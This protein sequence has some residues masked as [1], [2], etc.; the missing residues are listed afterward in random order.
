MWCT[1]V[2]SAQNS[3]HTKLQNS[4]SPSL[5][6]QPLSTLGFITHAVMNYKLY[7][8]HGYVVRK[9]FLG[10]SSQQNSSHLH[11]ALHGTELFGDIG[12][13]HMFLTDFELAAINAV[14]EVFPEPADA[15]AKGCFLHF[16]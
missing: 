6:A 10:H 14:R 15:V 4:R 11:R 12:E 16:R 1:N 8:I 2:D 7:T 5:G 9:E 13:N 3:M